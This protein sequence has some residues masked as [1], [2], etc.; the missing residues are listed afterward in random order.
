MP[1]PISFRQ[2]SRPR[3]ASVTQL[4]ILIVVGQSSI[5]KLLRI[6]LKP[7]GYELLEAPDPK[8]SLQLL[9]ERPDLVILDLELTDIDELE[10]LR[11]MR[12]RDKSVPIIMLS[13]RGSEART[14]EALDLGADDF[15]TK[16]FDTNELVVRIRVAARHWSYGDDDRPI[17]QTGDLSVDLVR[18]V[19]EVA[20]REVRLPAKEYELLRTLAQHAGK[21]LTH[22]FLLTE[23]QDEPT[24]VSNLRVRVCKLRKKIEADPERPQHIFTEAGIGYRLRAPQAAAAI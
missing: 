18:R 8:T 20:G 15:V 2:R 13:N 17:F 11:K 23:L 6:G 10:L 12:R 14:A 16:P 4:K 7:L 5:R 24:D 3:N 19:V 1:S 22:E 21:V 9:S